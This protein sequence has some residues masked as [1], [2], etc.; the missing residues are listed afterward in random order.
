ML[1]TF[2]FTIGVPGCMLKAMT[3]SMGQVKAAVWMRWHLIS[4]RE[5]LLC[6]SHATPLAFSQVDPLRE[7]FIVLSLVCGVG[8]CFLSWLTTSTQPKPFTVD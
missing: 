1:C 5:V 6:S 7:C 8:S 2:T 4:C 3:D